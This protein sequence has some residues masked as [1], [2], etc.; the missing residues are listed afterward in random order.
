LIARLTSRQPARG[1]ELLSLRHSNTMQ[2]HHRNIFIEIRMV[3]TITSWHK[4]Y[5]VTGFTKI[6][7]RYLPN[8]VGGGLLYTTYDS[9]FR[10]GKSWQSLLYLVLP[11]R[12]ASYGQSRNDSGLGTV[13]Y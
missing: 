5:T 2:G 7:H 6:I 13:E 3:S 4:E 9:S 1:T 10:F 11:C 12:F 8:H